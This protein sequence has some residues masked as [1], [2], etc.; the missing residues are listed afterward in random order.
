[1]DR[2][3]I[4]LGWGTGNKELGTENREQRTGNGEQG[5]GNGEQRTGNWDWEIETGN[6]EHIFLSQLN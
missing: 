4:V 6:G 3:I 2:D 1:M 5:T